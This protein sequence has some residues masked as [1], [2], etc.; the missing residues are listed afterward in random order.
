MK[1]IK[2]PLEWTS[3]PF[4]LA[5]AAFALLHYPAERAFAQR[6]T[7][8][9]AGSIV[10]ASE[11]AVPGARVIVRNLATGAERTVESN[12]LGYYVVPALPT[13]PY[14]VTVSK[15]GFQTQSVPELILE[16]DQNATIRISLKVGAI[17][18]AVSV[19]AEAAAVDTRTATLSTVINQKQ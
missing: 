14:S 10:D 13:G 12:D 11:S 19:T 1:P 2:E 18:E 6:S 9:V 4:F 8:S 16:V 5:I 15:E 3:A 17:S 7:A